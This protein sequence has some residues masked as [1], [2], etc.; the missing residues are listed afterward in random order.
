M[1]THVIIPDPHA[2]Y[3]HNNDRAVWAGALIADVKPDVVVMLGDLADM[4]S[5]S[6]YD[7]GKKCFQ[8]RTY[9]ADVEVAL[10]FNERLFEAARKSKKKLPRRIAIRGNHEQRIERAIQLS[11]ELEGAIGYHDLDWDRHYD[12]VVEYEGNTPGHI[13]IDGVLYAHYF[14]SGV[15]GRP[16]GGEH[17]GY[18]FNQ[19][20]GCSATAG[21]THIFDHCVR[22]GVGPA[23]MGLVAG[24]F[25]DYDLDYAGET[26]K[27]FWRGIVIKHNVEG[28]VYD[29]ELVSMT[30]LKE[31]YR[32]LTD[33]VA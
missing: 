17:P 6:G 1:A 21:H 24:C 20:L 29:L 9:R 3:L 2:H 15:M 8:G 19:K 11:P 26:N 12:E 31:A 30:R 16:I 22:Y 14:V 23:R 13:S 5:L 32:H 10:D 33:N 27:M 25:F 28:G 18:T 4:P 7:K